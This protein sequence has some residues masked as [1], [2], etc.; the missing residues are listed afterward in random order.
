M[1]DISTISIVCVIVSTLLSVVTPF[2]FWFVGK[3]RMKGSLL[4][5]LTGLGVYIIS[6][7]LQA[8][9]W[10]LP[11]MD[12]VLT[13]LLGS[14]DSEVVIQ[15]VRCVFL[16]LVETA[17]LWL[18]FLIGR[19]KRRKPGSTMIFGTTYGAMAC[20]TYST[21]LVLSVAVIL[22]N[23]AGNGDVLYNLPMTSKL[24]V[25]VP[26]LNRGGATVLCYGL[27]SLFDL[28]F[29]ISACMM[30]FSSVR[31]ETKWQLPVVLLLN[32]FRTAPAILGSLNVW[33]WNNN[34]VA[35]IA[36]GVI[37]VVTVLIAYRDYLE[38]RGCIEMEQSE[39]EAP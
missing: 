32:I 15:M 6:L 20:L 38:L 25:D 29:Y 22:Q 37:T 10:S 11:D 17:V 27:R 8:V 13:R 28:L 14:T 35:M 21:M 39:K 5:V 9:L 18:Y 24:T 1:K 12:T 33:Y 4:S 30:L 3:L 31:R 2:I 7:L 23:A 26:A 16:A 36:I 34:I 19:K